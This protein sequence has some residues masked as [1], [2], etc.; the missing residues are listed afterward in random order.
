MDWNLFWTLLAQ[1]A[2]GAPIVSLALRLLLL[3]WEY[4]IIARRHRVTS[5]KIL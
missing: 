2:I 3:P 4:G 1:I 5:E